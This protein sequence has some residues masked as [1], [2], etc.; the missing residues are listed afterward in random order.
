MSTLGRGCWAARA[1]AAFGLI[2]LHVTALG[3]CLGAGVTSLPAPFTGDFRETWEQFP[4][5]YPGSPV[6]I[7]GGQAT[8]SGGNPFVWMTTYTFGTPGGLGLGAFTAK[9]FDGTHGYVTSISPGTA[10]INF[11]SPVSD[12]GGYWGYATEYPA[13]IFNFYDSLGSLIGTESFTYVSPNNDGSLQWQGWHSTIP[14]SSVVYSGHWV[15]NDSLRITVVPEPGTNALLL[16]GAV[17]V[18]VSVRLTARKLP[19]KRH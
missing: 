9:A 19:P 7:F 15:A 12:F 17:I 16:C 10:V 1:S 6:T 3:Q 13:A 11:Q 4:V 14:I 18:G 5:D 2:L 8:I